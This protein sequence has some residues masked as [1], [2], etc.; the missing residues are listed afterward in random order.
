MATRMAQ[1]SATRIALELG[2][3]WLVALVATTAYAQD[4]SLLHAATPP[5]PGRQEPLTLE[6]GSFMYREL[7]P[8]ARAER[9]ASRTTSSR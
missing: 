1:N 5:A 9:A 8:E 2:A 7:P 6:N 4:G 3:A